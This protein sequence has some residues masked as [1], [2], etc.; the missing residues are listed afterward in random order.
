MFGTA[1]D[2]RVTEIKISTRFGKEIQADTEAFDTSDA[3]ERVTVT[4]VMTK[5]AALPEDLRSE[6]M[7][8]GKNND[9]I[10]GGN[11]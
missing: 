10:N 11:S 9:G 2:P 3:V 5:V 4:T 8:P 1:E 6:A 7:Q